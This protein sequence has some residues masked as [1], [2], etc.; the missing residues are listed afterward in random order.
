MIN[1]WKENEEKYLSRADARELDDACRNLKNF[2]RKKF[3]PKFSAH[4]DFRR[5]RHVFLI[6]TTPP[7]QPAQTEYK[8]NWGGEWVG[9]YPTR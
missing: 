8:V 7:N 3:F 6:A 2:Q 9:G 5:P 1:M 4:Q